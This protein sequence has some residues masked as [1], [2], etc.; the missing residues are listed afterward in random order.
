MVVRIFYSKIVFPI[1]TL[2]ARNLHVLTFGRVQIYIIGNA[3]AEKSLEKN[4]IL[5]F[6][7]LRVDSNCVFD[8]TEI[9]S[10]IYRAGYRVAR[11]HA[12]SLRF[13]HTGNRMGLT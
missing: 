9:V 1:T 11:N 7:I 13:T 10:R 4:L 3:P 5:S 12:K 6:N 2:Y 8:Y